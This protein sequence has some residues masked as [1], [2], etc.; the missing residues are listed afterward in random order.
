[1]AG[2]GVTEQ[3]TQRPTEELLALL[4]DEWQT[5]PA[6]NWSGEVMKCLGDTEHDQEP[7]GANPYWD[8]IR[9][10]PI[11]D[12]SSSIW[13]RRHPVEVDWFRTRAEVHRTALVKTYSWS[14]PTPADVA[15]IVA[16]LDGRGVVEIGAG[17]GYWAWQLS[18]AE[19]DVVAYDLNAFGD[20][21]YCDPVQYHPVHKGAPD[22]A[23]E[24]PDRALLLCWPPYSDPMATKALAAYGG[25]LLIYV[26]EPESGCTA[27][28]DF[29]T[30]LAAGWTEIGCSPRHATWWGI[31]DYVTAFRRG[32][33]S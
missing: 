13:D 24:Y 6:R 21:T 5:A 25:D 27:D 8:I 32:T 12:L 33:S 10:L 14:I 15:W 20:N 28:D 19:V 23:A 17:T 7:V 29:F 9:L 2:A 4:R 30:A 3:T 1:M 26:G 16:Q 18:Q 31:H 11:A 22:A